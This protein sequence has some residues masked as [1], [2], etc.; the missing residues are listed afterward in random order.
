MGCC[1]AKMEER[2]NEKFAE[3]QIILRKCV[4][5]VFVTKGP[6]AVV[7]SKTMEPL[8][9]HQT[10]SGSVCCAAVKKLKCRLTCPLTLHMASFL[11]APSPTARSISTLSKL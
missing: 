10:C 1:C 11:V 3:S 7:R 2:V 4:G 5:P 6:Q 8:F 9:L